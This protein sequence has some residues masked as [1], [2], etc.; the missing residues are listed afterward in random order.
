M[1]EKNWA[2]AIPNCPNLIL[3]DEPH[4]REGLLTE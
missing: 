3:L 2:G 1:F 4:H